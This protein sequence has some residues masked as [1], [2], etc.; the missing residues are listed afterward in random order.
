ME[1]DDAVAAQP[2]RLEQ[3]ATAVREGLKNARLDA[4]RGGVLGTA[5]IGASSHASH[6]F[7]AR[8]VRGGRRAL[9]LDAA[10][11]FGGAAGHL[12]DSFVFVSEG[13]RSRE[14]IEA[15]AAV[16]G[17]PRLGL[18]NDLSSPM[19]EQVDEVVGLDHGPDS[20]VYTVGYL[21]T[22]QAFGLLA[23]ALDDRDEGDDW[24]ALPELVGRTL[25]DQQEPARRAAAAL[26]SVSSIDVVAPGFFR[27][28]AAEG[29]LL[30]REATRTPAAAFE[31]YQYLHGPMEPLG[32]DTGCVLIG[33][34][35]EI[36]LARYVARIGTP[37]VLLTSRTVEEQPGLTV[38]R[39]PEGP[40]LTRTILQVLPLQLVTGELARTRGL[41][42]GAFRYHQADT[43]LPAPPHPA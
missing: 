1:F 21:S 27:A 34:D 28:S 19:A 2:A 4:W 15:I 5:S 11:L 23:T 36:E 35:R 32:P 37:T 40:V 6:A 10:D 8:L 30:L 9:A 43:K 25:D 26:A 29:A 20:P 22:L 13:G 14:T 31:T 16:S 42:I 39:V 12:A 38:L 17:L 41:T 3:S 24:E 18:T 33:D 7:V